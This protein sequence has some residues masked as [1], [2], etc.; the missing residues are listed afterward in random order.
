MVSARATTVLRVA[1]AI[2][3]GVLT[4][5][6]PVVVWW[7]LTHYSA[8]STG[9]VVLAVLVPLLAV[10]LWRRGRAHLWPVLRLP[11]LIMALIFVGV[12]TDDARYV[13]ALPV[14]INAALLVA[15]GASLVVPMESGAPMP[16]IERF[17]R[18]QD[19]EL[20]PAKQRHCRQAT[21]VWC[22]FF[23]LNGSAAAVLALMAPVRWW[24]VYTGGVAYALM[25]LL[26]AGEYIVRKARFR[27]YGRAPHDLLLRKLFPPREHGHE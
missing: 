23:F 16:M 24:A 2:T 18:L 6:Y 10:R 1:A 19:P 7:S 13:L 17:A 21:L 14:L 8:R 22:V 20:T 4:V 12:L 3:S 5:I 9:L 11:L 25:G 27:E 26:F 15:F